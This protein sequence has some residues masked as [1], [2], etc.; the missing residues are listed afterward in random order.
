LEN[1][2]WPGNVRELRNIMERFIIMNPQQ[3]IDLFDLP[4]SILRR[5]VLAEASPEQNQTL[6]AAREKFERE[7]I[8]EKLAESKGNVS[9]TAQVLQIERSNLYRKMRQLGI[10]YSGREDSDAE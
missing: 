6:H 3:R 5:T 8:L 9:R 2:P 7:Y 4:E 1:Y 10:P